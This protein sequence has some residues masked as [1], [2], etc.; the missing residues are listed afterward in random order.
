MVRCLLNMVGSMSVSNMKQVHAIL[1]P[2]EHEYRGWNTDIQMNGKFQITSISENLPSIFRDMRST[3]SEP[4]W[5]QIWRVF[6]PWTNPYEANTAMSPG[7]PVVS[8]HWSFCCLFGSLCIPTSKK[9]QSLHY[10]SFVRGIHRWPVNS[11]H[12]GPVSRKKS[13]YL[14]TSSCKGQMT[15]TLHYMVQMFEQI[16]RTLNRENPSWSFSDMD[17]A[18]SGSATCLHA[19][20]PEVVW[21]YPSS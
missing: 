13:F 11:P 19:Q 7:R 16:H 1:W 14:M 6:A 21:Q 8:N 9:H 3:K 17:S 5:Y 15:L 4:H 18:K 12:K 20:L 10:W 2:A